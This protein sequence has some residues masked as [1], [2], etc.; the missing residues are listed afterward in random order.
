MFNDNVVGVVIPCYNE[1]NLIIRT[2][3][4]IPKFIDK[5]I[6]V[7][8]GSTDNTQS[9]VETFISKDGS[10]KFEL[11]NNGKN[12]GVGRTIM[13]GYN[14]SIEKEIDI[15]VVMAGDN[16]MDPLY[17]PKLLEPIIEGKADYTKGNRLTH[18]DYRKMP[19]FRRFGNSI[20]SLLTKISTGYWD[21]IDPQNGYTAASKDAL[22]SI[23]D[24]KV[25][26]G[27]G[28]NSVMLTSLN[29]S[30]KKVLDVSIPPV[31]GEEKSG[32]K[33]GRYMI[34]TS[35]ILISGFFRRINNKYG[36]LRLH[37]ILFYYYFSFLFLIA[38]FALLYRM[39]YHRLYVQ[40]TLPT[41]TTLGALF[42]FV[43]GIQLLLSAFS[44]DSDN[45]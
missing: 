23:I 8:D 1:E 9:I 32:I 45:K 31:Y 29:I 2:L 25:A 40:D 19:L 27:Y 11:I 43:T 35:W 4:T 44:A 15:T 21:I 41:N 20:L 34:C 12:F 18:G 3:E 10:S 38:S 14:R 17:L 33:I 42:S 13:I 22:S 6:V 37:P 30:K 28:Y 26:G 39:V 36:G 16:Q 5:V 7:N 24:S